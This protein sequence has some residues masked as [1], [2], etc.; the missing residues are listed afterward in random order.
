MALDSILALQVIGTGQGTAR[1]PRRPPARATV[2]RWRPCRPTAQLGAGSKY[3]PRLPAPG[4]CCDGRGCRRCGC[5][6][7]GQMQ[8]PIAGGWPVRGPSRQRGGSRPAGQAGRGRALSRLPGA[9]GLMQAAHLLPAACAAL[10]AASLPPGNG[11]GPPPA[12]CRARAAACGPGSCGAVPAAGLRLA[13]I[14]GGKAGRQ[15]LIPRPAAVGCSTLSVAGSLSRPA[16]GLGGSPQL[17]G[18]PA[19]PKQQALRTWTPAVDAARLWGCKSS[20]RSLLQAAGR[21]A[22]L[23]SSA[24]LAPGGPAPATGH[25]HGVHAAAL[26]Q[27]GAGPGG[28][29]QAP[30][31][32][33]SRADAACPRAWVQAKSLS[34]RTGSALLPV[35]AW[36]LGRS[37]VS[38]RAWPSA[39]AG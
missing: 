34:G 36:Q 5:P 25:R 28:C 37:W 38:A 10:S 4:A 11:E 20:A 2:G 17:G 31:T 27:A 35:A 29:G 19:R 18:R 6:A 23:P 12:V 13:Q 16:A 24:S 8:A 14:A 1:P 7:Q 21:L 32:R 22:D 39:S 15:G 26:P 3:L 33:C 30:R 9:G